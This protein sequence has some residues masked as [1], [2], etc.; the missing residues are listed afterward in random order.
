MKGKHKRI[1]RKELKDTTSIGEWSR[2]LHKWWKLS[3]LN[4]IEFKKKREDIQ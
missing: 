1:R 4:K 2:M 3:V